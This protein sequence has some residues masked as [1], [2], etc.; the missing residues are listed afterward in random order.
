MMGNISYDRGPPTFLLPPCQVRTSLLEAN[1]FS[2]HSGKAI[3]SK[4]PVNVH[5]SAYNDLPS[6]INDQA[7]YSGNYLII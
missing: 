4:V 3:G 6:M 5:G 1:G 7:C 2:C